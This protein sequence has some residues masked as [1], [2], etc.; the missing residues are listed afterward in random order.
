HSAQDND[1]IEHLRLRGVRQVG[2]NEGCRGGFRGP[3]KGEVLV[4][5]AQDDPRGD[6]GAVGAEDAAVGDLGLVL[7]IA[8]ARAEHPAH[9]AGGWEPMPGLENCWRVTSR[10]MTTDSLFFSRM[11]RP[12]VVA[13]WAGADA[14]A[15]TAHT[16]TRAASLCLFSMALFLSAG[17]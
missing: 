11:S 9:R 7:H 5:V 12:A 6:L 2:G 14:A 13:S 10:T 16:A 17:G 8:G 15:R 1:F 4:A 3:D